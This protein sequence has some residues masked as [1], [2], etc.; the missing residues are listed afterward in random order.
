MKRMISEDDTSIG[1]PKMPSSVMYMCPT[2]RLT[3][4]GW[5]AQFFP[6][7]S[8]PRDSPKLCLPPIFTRGKRSPMAPS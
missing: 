4:F 7:C 3:T 1:T 5:I 2:I 8:Q 6:Y